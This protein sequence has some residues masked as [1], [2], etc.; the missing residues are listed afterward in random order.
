[1]DALGGFGCHR[2]GVGVAGHI[3]KLALR[4][5]GL[6]CA[7]AAPALAAGSTV[8]AAGTASALTAGSAVVAAGTAPTLTPT[9]AHVAGVVTVGQVA[10][11]G[12]GGVQHHAAGGTFALALAAHALD[13]RHGGVDDVALVGVHRLHL[14]VAAGAD[15]ALCQT[16]CQCAEVILA[17]VA[18]AADVQTQLDVG[19]LHTV[20]DQACQIGQA[21]HR[22]AA[23]TD[24]CAH[25]LAG[26]AQD[27]RFALAEGGKAEIL[28]A[29]QV[30]DRAEVVHSRLQTR[31]SG[32]VQ[33]DLGV[34]GGRGFGSGSG[35]GRGCRGGLFGRGGFHGGGDLRF[36][37]LDLDQHLGGDGLKQLTGGE[38]QH[39]VAD[40]YIIAVHAQ[41]VAG[42][43]YGVLNGLGAHFHTTHN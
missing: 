25:M 42:S 29:H 6:G 17:L 3:G 4:H 37:L 14:V 36:R 23:A 38:F 34:I 27:G 33:L 26:D 15:D 7:V 41:R 16:L 24:E 31:V 32:D 40:V 20:D 13:V 21:L 43:L 8:V 5:V 22:F 9:A 18:V 11:V 1:M 30:E 12:V 35:F 19:T 10:G 28:H 39:F 2:L